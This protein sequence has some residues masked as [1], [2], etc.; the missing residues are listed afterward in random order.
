MNYFHTIKDSDI[1]D[2]PAPLPS[3]YIKRPTAKGI[4]LDG[5][6]KIALLIAEGH[7]LFPGG[8]I[9]DGELSEEAFIRE[10]K[11]EIG[12]TIVIDTMLGMTEQWRARD[13]K[14]YEIYFFVAHVIGE[15]GVPTTKDEGELACE[16][17]WLHKDEVLSLLEGQVKKS[18]QHSYAAQFNMRSH[19]AVFEK[20]RQESESEISV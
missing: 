20:Y 10:C 2:N 13:K 1:F 15:K 6:G 17:T 4:V 5:E 16:L 14:V 7:G 11:E 19:L 3:E 18:M 9:E 8:G 12:C